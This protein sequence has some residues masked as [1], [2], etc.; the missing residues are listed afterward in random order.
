MNPPF[1]EAE[2]KMVLKAFNPKK[3]LG[4]TGSPRTHREVVVRYTGGEFRKVTSKDCIQG[5]IASAIFRNQVLDS[6][7]RELG[8]LG[9]TANSGTFAAD[10]V[11]VFRTVGLITGGGDQQGTSPCEGLRRSK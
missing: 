9:G 2:V 1:T 3:P 8:D 7:L 6:L 5:S 4:L 10:V 11:F